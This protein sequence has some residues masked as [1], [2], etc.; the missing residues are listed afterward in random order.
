MSRLILALSVL[1]LFSCSRTSSAD[2][3]RQRAW[4]ADETRVETHTIEKRELSAHPYRRE[5]DSSQLEEKRATDGYSALKV[6]EAGNSRFT[7]DSAVHPRQD[8]LRREELKATQ[9][10]H[11]AVLSCSDSRV[12]PELVFDQGIGDLF[13][14]R[15]AGEVADPAAVASLEYA[16][17]HLGV[18]MILIMGHTS[19]GA[20]KTTL[21]LGSE[22]SAGSKDL[23]K[24]VAAIRPNIK[25]FDLTSAGPGLEHAV[26]A[27]VN[28]VADGLLKRSKI[29][30][31]ASEKHGLRISRAIY[32]LD[33]GTVDFW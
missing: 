18:K 6:L 13:V 4:A 14:V 3:Y 31:E 26:R 10:P 5:N 22:K 23:D 19:C 7:Q 25:S 32:N 29:I 27:Q 16:V 24:L 11:T 1:F 30:N 28:G 8:K 33:T 15:T 21:S 20:V 9:N 17:E 2:Y 12:S